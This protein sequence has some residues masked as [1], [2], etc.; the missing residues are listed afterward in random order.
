MFTNR[1]GRTKYRDEFADQ[2]YKYCLLGAKTSELAQMFEVAESTILSWIE[3]YDEFAEAI[4]DGGNRADAQV[5][6]S[7]HRRA[8]GFTKT[9]KTIKTGGRFGTTK[10]TETIY[11]PPDVSAATF[12]LKNRQRNKWN[13]VDEALVSSLLNPTAESEALEYIRSRINGI[14]AR[15][16]AEPDTKLTEQGA[17]GEP[18]VE[19]GVLGENRPADSA[20]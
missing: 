10:T 3:R 14:S 11:Y 1:R 5:A 7:L 2:A 19:L 20:R 12:W 4:R 18:E 15:L 6:Y 8:V 9:K 17:G 16:K 13:V